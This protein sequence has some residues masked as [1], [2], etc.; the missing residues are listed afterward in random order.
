MTVAR[1]RC[2][3]GGALPGTDRERQ[4]RTES[5]LFLLKE[6]RSWG[7]HPPTLVWHG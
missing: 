3:F 4:G 6:R 7:V 5:D 2:D 1:T